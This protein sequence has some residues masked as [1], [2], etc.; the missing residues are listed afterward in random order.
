M[1]SR[2][3]NVVGSNEVPVDA[4]P[5]QVVRHRLVNELG[6]FPRIEVRRTIKLP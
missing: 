5:D 4:W 2:M 6:V 3:R 1:I